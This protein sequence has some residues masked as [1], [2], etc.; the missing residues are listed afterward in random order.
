MDLFLSLYDFITFF[1]KLAWR[2]S[3]FSWYIC[4]FLCRLSLGIGFKGWRNTDPQSMDPLADLVHGPPKKTIR[5]MTIRNSTYRL[6]CFVFC[7]CCLLHWGNKRRTC[8]L[9]KRPVFYMSP[10]DGHVIFVCG[11]IILTAVSS[12]YGWRQERT[13]ILSWLRI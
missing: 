4:T 7:Y 12:L 11:C 6:F 10:R 5:K 9:R 2:I 13:F 8:V 3:M 1:Y